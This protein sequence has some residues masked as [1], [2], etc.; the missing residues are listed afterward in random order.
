MTILDEPDLAELDFEPE[1][2]PEVGPVPARID[3]DIYAWAHQ[4]GG[5]YGLDPDDLEAVTKALEELADFTVNRLPIIVDSIL[6]A[7]TGIPLTN[8]ASTLSDIITEESTSPLRNS[9]STFG[10]MLE[11]ICECTPSRHQLLS[12]STE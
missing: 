5:P 4:V 9:T 6:T 10:E 1:T 3:D 12:G 7:L 2:E 8:I 11:W